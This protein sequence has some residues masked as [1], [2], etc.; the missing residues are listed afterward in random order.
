MTNYLKLRASVGYQ[1][2]DFDNDGSVD[3]PN[4]GSDYY[5]Y[6][7]L[8]HRINCRDLANSS[9]PVTNRSSVLTPTS[10]S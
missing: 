8:S 6:L 3:D 2:I 7:L 4:D 5:A 1:L 9:L 10:S